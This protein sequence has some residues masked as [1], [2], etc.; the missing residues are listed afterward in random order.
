MGIHRD[1]RE[2]ASVLRIRS[3]H[4]LK[5]GH[6]SVIVVASRVHVRF[7]PVRL[8]TR[9]GTFYIVTPVQT[10]EKFPAASEIVRVPSATREGS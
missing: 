2:R 4:Y 10:I 3:R 7:V 1:N 5:P 9:S 6:C 8:K